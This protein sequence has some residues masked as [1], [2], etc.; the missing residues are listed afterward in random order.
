LARVDE[1]IAEAYREGKLVLDL[2]HLDLEELPSTIGDLDSLQVL[3]LSHN[4]LVSLPDVLA[5]LDRLEHLLVSHNQLVSL[6]AGVAAL[7]RLRSLRL[8]HNPLREVPPELLASPSLHELNLAG[9]DVRSLGSRRPTGS[10][11]QYLNL[12]GCP[13][14]E[15]VEH[16]G[17]LARLESLNLRGTGLASV[18]RF[19]SRLP[20]L[21]LLDLRDNGLERLPGE[22]GDLPDNAQLRVEGNPLVEPFPKLVARGTAELRAYL[23]SLVSAIK[24]YE[25]KVLLVGER[26]VGKS[27]LTASLRDLDFVVD[28]PTTH[29]LDIVPLRVRHPNVEADLE[30]KVWDFGGQ[31]EYQVSHQFLFSKRSLYL[32]VWSARAGIEHGDVEGW[33]KRIRLRVGP[34]ARVLIV[35]THGDEGRPSIDLPGLVQQFPGMISGGFV[36]DNKSGAGVPELLHA[37]AAEAAQLPQMGEQISARWLDARDELLA[38]PEPQIAYA[39][40]TGICA[41][42]RISGGEAATWTALL[43]D[44]GYVIHHNDDEGLRDVVVLKPEWLTKAI[45]HV[46]EDHVTR[47]TAGVLD[48]KRLAEVWRFDDSYRPEHYPYFLRLMEK[49][50]VSYRLLDRDASLVGQLVPRERP[51]GQ[52]KAYDGTEP[53]T[54]AM[55][56]LELICEMDEEPP[57][58]V[59][60]LTVRHHRFSLGIHWQRGVLLRHVRYDSTALFEIGSERELRLVVTAPSPDYFFSVLRDGL[61]DVLRRWPGLLFELLVPCPRPRGVPCDG[62][63]LLHTLLKR[64]ERGKAE[65]DCPK[66]DDPINVTSL[67]TGFTTDQHEPITRRLDALVEDVRA[68]STD[69][70]RAVE[71]SATV[72]VMMR[73][74]LHSAAIEVQDC[75]RLFTLVPRDHRKGLSHFDARKLLRQHYELTLWCEQPDEWHKTASEPYLLSDP[76]RWLVRLAPYAAKVA[77]ALRVAV[78]LSAGVAGV[79]LS[80]ADQER[81]QDEIDLM[82]VIAEQLPLTITPSQHALGLEDGAPLSG[83]DLRVFREILLKVDPRRAFAGLRRVHAAS[84]D[85]SW[86]CDAHYRE[87][88]P[89]L[90]NLERL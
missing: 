14:A 51:S 48:H 21:V 43:N 87:Y 72:G 30:L 67:L 44:L 27:S 26:N 82:K 64:R 85:F 79:I 62:R 90:P 37:I 33:L 76:A 56:R 16:L 2:S 77:K 86:V 50:D 31:V 32:L 20:N 18:P 63:F 13:L 38:L 83:S 45:S 24:T 7:P 11:L 5:R 17:A 40:W 69:I 29:G 70:H 65:A 78:P 81:L 88:D 39:D 55:R 58:L 61:E 10:V 53:P 23:R 3:E 74:L 84:G 42:H 46:L 80:E 89:G 19:L 59:A 15:P 71:Q 9:C 36:V 28:R 25:A 6:P 60:W 41:G 49:F 57:G 1:L 54:P 12:E 66:C 4:K 75:P 35:A 52:I 8:D 34:E 68:M 22:L 73:S 47:D